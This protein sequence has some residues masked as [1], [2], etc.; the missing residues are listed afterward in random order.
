MNDKLIK[1]AADYLKAKGVSGW[2]Q[3]TNAEFFYGTV[4]KLQAQEAPQETMIAVM[5]LAS[6][7]SAFAQKLES[8]GVIVRDGKKRS[9]SADL[10]SS[11]DL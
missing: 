4:C 11:F 2:S 6:N 7:A 5:Q 10:L 8:A 1:A 3:R 9:P